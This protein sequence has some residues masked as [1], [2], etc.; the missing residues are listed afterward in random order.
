MGMIERWYQMGAV[1]VWALNA[2]ISRHVILEMP[3]ADTD[4][5]KAKREA[6]L[7]WASD[8]FDDSGKRR[9]KDVGQKYIIIPV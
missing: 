3:P 9:I 7:N 2:Q 4:E 8:Y 5:N 6:L 1:K